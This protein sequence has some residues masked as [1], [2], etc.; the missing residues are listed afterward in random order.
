[1]YSIESTQGMS[2]SGGRMVCN[3]GVGQHVQNNVY[4]IELSLSDANWN[5]VRYDLGYPVISKGYSGAAHAVYIMY[6][7]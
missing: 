2:R 4:C 1:M 6:I 3:A 5:L 7:Q